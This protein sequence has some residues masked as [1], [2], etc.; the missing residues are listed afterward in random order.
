VIDF[1]TSRAESNDVCVLRYTSIRS[2]PRSL[3]VARP[4]LAGLQ[5]TPVR[6]PPSKMLDLSRTLRNLGVFPFHPFIAMGRDSAVSVVTRY[7]LDGPG[8]ESR[9][10]WTVRGS[11]PGGGGRSEDR[12]PMGVDGPGIE[13]RWGQDFPH[14]SRPALRPT[15]PPKQWVPGLSRG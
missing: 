13:S 2:L 14:P 12:I 15:Q 8:I 1:R 5:A 4:S 9:W 6:T 10:G 3:C 7:G 11:N